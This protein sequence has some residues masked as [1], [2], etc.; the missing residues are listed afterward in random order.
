[1]P[2]KKEHALRLT[3]PSRVKAAGPRLAIC[4]E[5]TTASSLFDAGPRAYGTPIRE[6]NFGASRRASACKVTPPACGRE[7][8]HELYRLLLVAPDAAR[9]TGLP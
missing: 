6:L 7:P 9:G 2:S 4:A 5:C 8:Q 1:M 3:F